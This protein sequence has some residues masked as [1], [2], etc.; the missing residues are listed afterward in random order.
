MMGINVKSL[1]EEIEELLKS[2][3]ITME[4]VEFRLV[5]NILKKKYP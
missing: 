3:K 4:M 5:V 2:D 1:L